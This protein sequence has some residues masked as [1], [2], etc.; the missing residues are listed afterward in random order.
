MP[1]SFFPMQDKIEVY[2]IETTLNFYAVK[3]DDD[4]IEEEK[5]KEKKV[6]SLIS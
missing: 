2:P 1:W 4:D 6:D 5:E 3:E